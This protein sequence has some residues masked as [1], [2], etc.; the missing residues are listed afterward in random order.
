M[1]LLYALY[2]IYTTLQGLA[3][4]ITIVVVVGWIVWTCVRYVVAYLRRGGRPMLEGIAIGLLMVVLAFS[5]VVVF[6]CLLGD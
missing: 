1:W 2:L 6:V 5:I 3:V 4:A